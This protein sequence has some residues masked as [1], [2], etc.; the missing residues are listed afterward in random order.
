MVYIFL[1]HDLSSLI[2]LL[3]I[4]NDFYQMPFKHLLIK[5]HFFLQCV[6][7]IDYADR[8]PDTQ[9]LLKIWDGESAL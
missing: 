8:F 2:I 7:I 4:T 6:D 1:F 3:E 9:E 5:L